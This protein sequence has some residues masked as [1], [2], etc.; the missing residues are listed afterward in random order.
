MSYAG[1]TFRQIMIG[2]M[3]SYIGG[4]TGDINDGSLVPVAGD[5]KA[6]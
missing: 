2:D 5:I 3:K 1:Q 4:L 6:T